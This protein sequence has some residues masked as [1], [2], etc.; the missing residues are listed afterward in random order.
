MIPILFF[1]VR[2]GKTAGN[3][4]NKYRA[5]S[6]EPEA[7]LTGEGRDL[8]RESALWLQKSGQKF[9]LIISD[10]LDRAVETRNIL[11]GI[12]QIGTAETDARLRPLNVGELT[13]KSKADFPIDKYLKDKNLVIPGGESVNQ[14]N[15]RQA[16]FFDDV[17]SIVEKLGRP[18]LLVGH[19]STVSF[20]HNHFNAGA[21]VGYEGLVNPAG[22]L[23]FTSKGIEPLTNKRE[24]AQS[25]M[26]QGTATSGYVE[27][28]ENR[29]PRSCWNCY[30]FSRD[31]ID[32]PLCGN[33]V[34]RVD[35]ALTKQRTESGLVI[36]N[37]DGCCN[38]FRNK[39]G[40]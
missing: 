4:A 34:V 16:K 9:P 27:P 37:E 5:W 8:V 32:T 22:I 20:L 3:A 18:I 19:G 29:E 23:M 11:Q 15:A 2:H 10:D 14:F 25:S 6:N 1:V 36:V 17:A 26:A 28:S 21:A 38:Y 40:S 30:W 39:I 12:L 13:G 33:P 31:Q 35:P 7:Q 24:G